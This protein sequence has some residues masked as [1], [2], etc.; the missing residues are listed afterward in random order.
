[1]LP[2]GKAVLFGA[3]TASGD[4]V[5][6]LD[7]DT[8]AAKILFEGGQN[9]VW[10]PTGHIVFARGTTLM[11]APFD[12]AERVLTGDPVALLQGV[13]H[14][15]VSTA[16]DFALSATGTLVYVPGSAEIMTGAEL[17]WVDRSGSV[18]ERAVN[19]RLENP[20]DPRLSPAG[21][22]VVLTIGSPA[23]GE[24]WMYD[25]RGRPPIPLATEGDNRLAVWSPDGTQI[26]FSKA[27]L[28]NWQA[29]AIRADGTELEPRPLRS[30][31]LAAS[32]AV[33]SSAGEILLRTA[34]PADSDVVAM[35]ADGS[36]EVREVV[37]TDAQE[38]DSALSPDGRWLAYASNRTGEEEVWVKGYPD[39]APVRVSP[40]GG[41][42][43][44]W[45]ADGRELFYLDGPSMMAVSV[46]DADEFSFAAPVE[47]F[48]GGF[49]WSQSPGVRGYDV[50]R[51]GR[52][53][54]LQEEG[55]APGAPPAQMVVIQNWAEELKQRVPAN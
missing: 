14:P 20:R 37:A 3:L 23:T 15:N 18:I 19:T 48:R 50:A 4:A 2:G 13:R 43:P 52:F 17:V 46:E 6:V 30:E 26:A 5:G 16:A 39:G 32:P 38:Y 51:D 11:A 35:A 24:L 27:E 22:R 55:N 44:V 10:S 1:M 36:G 49:Y 21:D 47:L 40:S 9:P 45:S 8:G 29:V 12:L 33:W 54:M 42:E 53:L 31:A 34:P 28:G 7:I 25:L 41:F